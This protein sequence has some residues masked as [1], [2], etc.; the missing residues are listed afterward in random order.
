MKNRMKMLCGGLVVLLA[1]CSSQV[2]HTNYYFDSANGNDANSGTSVQTPFKSLAKLKELTLKGG[3]SV[4]LKSGT[5]F[6]EKLFLSCRGEENNPV[7]LG[8][9]GGMAK[10]HVKG[11]G[12][13]IIMKIT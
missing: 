12:V 7:V 13:D 1:S 6:T 3:D 4:L 2:T 9:Y 5:V 11:N 8:K 10:P